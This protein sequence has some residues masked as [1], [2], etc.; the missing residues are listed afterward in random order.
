MQRPRRSY[1]VELAQFHSPEYLEFL[2]RISPD[3]QEVRPAPKQPRR[4]DRL[5]SAA[6]DCTS[7]GLQYT[8]RITHGAHRSMSATPRTLQLLFFRFLFGQEY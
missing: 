6:L 2:Q 8:S 7:L 4:A 3:E 1:L 5:R